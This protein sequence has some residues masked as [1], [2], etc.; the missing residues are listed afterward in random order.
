MPSATLASAPTV[1]S[2]HDLE[3]LEP[4]SYAQR[5]VWVS[6]VNRCRLHCESQTL[7]PQTTYLVVD[8][9]A[10]TPHIGQLRD[11]APPGTV[12]HLWRHVV[13]GPNRKRLVTLK[14]VQLIHSAGTVGVQK[15][16]CALAA[17]IDNGHVLGLDV[18]VRNTTC[19]PCC[20][21]LWQ[22]RVY[23]RSKRSVDG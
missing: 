7:T 17:H 14:L 19:M 1:G 5:S 15:L 4:T 20:N 6:L 2:L 9:S 8:C 3:V 16:H 10:G 22:W 12:C 18:Q 23:H 13:V 11:R 21:C